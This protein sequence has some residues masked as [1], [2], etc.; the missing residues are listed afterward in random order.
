MQIWWLS[1]EKTLKKRPLRPIADIYYNIQGRLGR[2]SF[3]FLWKWNWQKSD[4]LKT[5]SFYEKSPKNLAHEK[6]KNQNTQW[7]KH[8]DPKTSIKNAIKKLV[9]NFKSKLE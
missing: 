5:I 8:I 2:N 1:E 9:K 4:L 7:K 3:L 6:V